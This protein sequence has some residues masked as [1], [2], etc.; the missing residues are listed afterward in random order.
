MVIWDSPGISIAVGGGGLF[1]WLLF[2]CDRWYLSTFTVNLLSNAIEWL[3]WEGTKKLKSES[4]RSPPP[5]IIV[6]LFCGLK[7]TPKMPYNSLNLNL[8]SNY[9]HKYAA[10]K[11]SIW[12]FVGKGGKETEKGNWVRRLRLLFLKHLILLKKKV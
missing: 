9:F 7:I 6:K 8:N 4:V 2:L 12:C 5:A 3:L 11:D 1:T 10:Q